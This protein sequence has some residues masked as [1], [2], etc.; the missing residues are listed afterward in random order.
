[1]IAGWIDSELTNWAAWCRSG[2]PPGPP[3]QRMAASAEGKYLAPSDMGEEPPPPQPKPNRERAEIVHS[4]YLDML[5]R[6]ERRVLVLRYVDGWPEKRV[7]KIMRISRERYTVEL[8]S[9]AR[10]VGEAFSTK[11][12]RCSTQRK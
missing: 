5:N 4:V 11:E 9:A 12:A 8:I 6:T 2:P 3:I 7:P 1:M 10:M